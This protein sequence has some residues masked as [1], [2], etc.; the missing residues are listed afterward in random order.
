MPNNWQNRKFKPP[1]LYFSLHSVSWPSSTL[2]PMTYSLSSTSSASLIG[3]ALPWR[4]LVWCGYATKNLSWNDQLR[5]VRGR[6]KLLLNNWTSVSEHR[7]TLWG[8]RRS[9]FQIHEKWPAIICV[10]CQTPDTASKRTVTHRP[11]CAPH[12]FIHILSPV[13]CWTQRDVHQRFGG[14]GVKEAICLL[15]IIFFSFSISLGTIHCLLVFI[16]ASNVVFRH[17]TDFIDGFNYWSVKLLE[18]L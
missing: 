4:S 9:Y 14:T 10:L 3:F 8:G 5:W 18:S 11:F 6:R 16:T 7:W 12:S 2:S 1:F 13:I 17:F 15:L